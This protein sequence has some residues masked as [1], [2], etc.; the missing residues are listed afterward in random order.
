[1]LVY[2]SVMRTAFAKR[3]GPFIVHP[4]PRNMRIPHPTKGRCRR[5]GDRAALQLRSLT[6]RGVG[7]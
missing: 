6:D 2:A 1:M 4:P 3:R 5:A 7:R